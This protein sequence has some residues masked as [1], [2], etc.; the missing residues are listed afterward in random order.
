M[1]IK[2]ITYAIKRGLPHYSSVSAGVTVEVAEG[3]DIDKAWDLAKQQAL[4][5]ADEDPSWIKKHGVAD[6]LKEP[7]EK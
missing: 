2:E 3:E 1:K 7:S 6:S 4:N 5:N